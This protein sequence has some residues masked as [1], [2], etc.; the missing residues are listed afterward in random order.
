MKK[1]VE[2]PEVDSIAVFLTLMLM[3]VESVHPA[4]RTKEEPSNYS[5]RNLIS[6]IQLFKSLSLYIRCIQ[7]LRYSRFHEVRAAARHFKSTTEIKC[8]A[9]VKRGT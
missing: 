7:I 6:F 8:P 2:N 3:Q 1:P 9:L 5:C 4:E